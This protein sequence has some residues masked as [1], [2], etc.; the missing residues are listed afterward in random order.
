MPSGTIS[1][2]ANIGGSSFLNTVTKTAEHPNPYEVELPVGT[3]EASYVQTDV[4]TC[5]VTLP[6]DH[7]LTNGNYDAY[8]TESDVDK[9]AVGCTGTVAGNDLTLDVP[10][11]GDDFPAADPTDMVVC[12]QVLI[13]T[14]ID[15]DEVEMLAISPVITAVAVT[16]DC[17]VDFH[18]VTHDQITTLRIPANESSVWWADSGV[19]N[20]MTGDPIT[21]CHASNQSTTNVALLKILVLED[22]TP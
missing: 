11:S 3:L 16:T 13:N 10:L 12:K 4:D 15:G 1:I 19:T 6:A 8:W 20:P 9:I 22:P 18:D 21:H 5:V 7:G 17:S 14:T 2:A